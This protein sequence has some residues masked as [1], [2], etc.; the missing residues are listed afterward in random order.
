MHHLGI[1]VQLLKPQFVYAAKPPL[2]NGHQKLQK[3]VSIQYIGRFYV[4]F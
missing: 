3:W 1:V 4:N 2:G